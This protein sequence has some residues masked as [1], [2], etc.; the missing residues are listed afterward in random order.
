MLRITIFIYLEGWWLKIEQY[1]EATDYQK[2]AQRLT[3]LQLAWIIIF[4]EGR[5]L[6]FGLK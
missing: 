6:L 1:D 2:H 3:D 5:R 4:Y